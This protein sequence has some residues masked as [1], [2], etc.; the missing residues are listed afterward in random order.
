MEDSLLVGMRARD[1]DGRITYVNP[2]FCQMTG[3]EAGELLGRPGKARLVTASN[4]HSLWK[5]RETGV[6]L[7]VADGV[8]NRISAT[9]RFVALTAIGA[10]GVIASLPLLSTTFDGGRS[11]GTEYLEF[12]RDRWPYV[13]AG[14]VAFHESRARRGEAHDLRG[15]RREAVDLFVSGRG[16]EGIRRAP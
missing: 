6:A 14:I 2:A 13:T 12:F 7:C 15:R 3:F 8:L 5:S 1:M 11:I 4:M 10:V 16:P 9:N